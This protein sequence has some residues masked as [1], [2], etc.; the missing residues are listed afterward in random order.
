[1]KLMKKIVIA[2]SFSFLFINGTQAQNS[3]NLSKG[4]KYT[5]ESKTSTHSNTEIQGQSMETSVDGV[6]TFSVEVTDVNSNGVSLKNTIS[7]VLM[8]ISMMG[9]ESKFDSDNPSDLDG[10]YG[11]SLKGVVKVP[12][13]V[14]MD[15][16]G[17]IIA[18]TD[19]A[20]DSNKKEKDEMS[21]SGYGAT[22]AFLALPS[23]LKVGTTWTSQTDAGGNKTNMQYVVKS[24]NGDIAT[25]SQTGT[26]QS[27][28]E[29]E[30]QGMIITTKNT[31]NVIGEQIVNIKNNIIQKSTTTTDSKGTVEVMGQEMPM[32]AKTVTTTTVTAN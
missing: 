24:I 20:S 30:Q 8:N 7:K 26:I 3:L 5:V 19:T 27:V 21:A 22:L 1:M 18:A 11:A 2:L 25:I 6:S 4:S 32:T 14:Q 15:K 28:T 16:S 23:N 9:Q 13:N 12:Q 17:K 31:G 10:P 29:M